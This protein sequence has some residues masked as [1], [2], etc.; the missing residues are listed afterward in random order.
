MSQSPIAA[1]KRETPLPRLI[2]DSGNTVEREENER[3]ENAV[4]NDVFRLKHLAQ[5]AKHQAAATSLHVMPVSSAFTEKRPILLFTRTY[6]CHSSPDIAAPS[7]WREMDNS[8]WSFIIRE[9]SKKLLLNRHKLTRQQSML[10]GA[11]TKKSPTF[12]RAFTCTDLGGSEL[13]LD[14][15]GDGRHQIVSEGI[16][17]IV[18]VSDAVAREGSRFLAG[19]ARRASPQGAI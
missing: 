13:D 5:Q 15:G 2:P 19:R 1:A 18:A 12:R 3:L 17:D 11:R 10:N 9:H 7:L 8:Y 16:C 14:A 4:S 6:A